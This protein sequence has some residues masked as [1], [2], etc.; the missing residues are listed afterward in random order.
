[1]NAAFLCSVEGGLKGRPQF[2]K[3]G[4]DPGCLAGMMGRFGLRMRM[5]DC[6]QSTQFDAAARVLGETKA[7]D[8]HQ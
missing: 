7:I 2:R 5:R 6:A 3:D 1:V 4:D 8:V